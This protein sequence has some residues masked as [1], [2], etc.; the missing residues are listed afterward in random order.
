LVCF[1]LL[2]WLIISV[3][4]AHC[5]L[6]YSSPFLHSSVSSFP[7]SMLFHRWKIQFSYPKT[8]N[9]HLQHQHFKIVLA[10]QELRINQYFLIYLYF[11]IHLFKLTTNV[12]AKCDLWAFLH[13]GYFGKLKLRL[14]QNHQAET[15]PN[16]LT[17]HCYRLVLKSNY[18]NTV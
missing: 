6:S 15:K 17:M 5:S 7:I 2:A 3:N 16:L 8:A 14:T 13:K 12:L 11:K 1:S 9:H 18:T 4:V 10:V